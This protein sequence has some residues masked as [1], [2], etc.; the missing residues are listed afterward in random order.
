MVDIRTSDEFIR[1]CAEPR[2]NDV[3]RICTDRITLPP[4]GV[5]LRDSRVIQIMPARDIPSVTITGGR[6]TLLDCSDVYLYKLGFRSQRLKTIPEG[7]YETYERSWKPLAVHATA[8]GNSQRIT[9]KHCSFSGH[10]DEIEIGPADHADWFA[11]HMGTPAVSDVL[12]DQC[13]VGPSFMNTGATI[14]DKATRAAFLMKR[15]FHN[16]GL[17]ATCV[18]NMTIKRTLFCGNNRRSPQ[19]AGTGVKL[20]R[21]IVNNWGTMAVGIHAGSSVSINACKFLRGPRSKSLPVAMVV[22]TMDS[23]FG[24]LGRASVGITK[25]SIEYGEGF[26][27]IR[28]GWE[29][30]PS[31]PPDQWKKATVAGSVL[32]PEPM[33]ET[34]AQIGCGDGLDV[35][36]G[37]ALNGHRHIPWVDDYSTSWP[38]PGGAA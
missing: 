11:N 4:T 24:V 26:G 35:A 31:T 8:P 30:W 10:T 12:I 3:V 19:I 21:C 13:V 32:R 27:A 5:T 20:E 38:M 36:I 15:E 25:N 18:E 17:A 34:L 2:A 37:A 7:L 16:H 33:A 23:P 1:Y 28:K 22:G 14:K 9:L 6:F 29:L